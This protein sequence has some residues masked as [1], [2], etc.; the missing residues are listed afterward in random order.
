ML[1]RRPRKRRATRRPPLS[2]S[3]SNSRASPF[4]L[5][6]S[7][8]GPAPK[9]W[10]P[11]SPTT[12]VCRRWSLRWS[13]TAQPFTGFDF[14]LEV[15]MKRTSW[16]RPSC[17]QRI[18]RFGLSRCNGGSCSHPRSAHRASLDSPRS[19]YGLRPGAFSGINSPA[20]RRTRRMQFSHSPS[21][22]CG[23]RQSNSQSA[24][25]AG[26]SREIRPT[27]HRQTVRRSFIEAPQRS[28]DSLPH[29]KM[30]LLLRLRQA[31]KPRSDVQSSNRQPGAAT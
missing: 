9:P 14:W 23:L 19:H 29:L 27:I 31:K 15:R 24:S 16:R 18:S 1:S 11:G 12:S 28:P 2:R 25:S 8:A 10:P 6:Q 5:R 17:A 26:T 30:Y 22:H 20:A 13:R 4:K 3:P 21:K 7:T